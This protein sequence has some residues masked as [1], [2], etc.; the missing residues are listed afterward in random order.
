M[1]CSLLFFIL[2]AG[3]VQT[4]S[5]Q[6]ISSQRA[7]DAS[8]GRV[9]VCSCHSSKQRVVRLIL[10]LAIAL[11]SSGSSAGVS[12]A[13]FSFFGFLK[14]ALMPVNGLAWIRPQLVAKFI[15]SL[16]R[17]VKRLTVSRLPLASIGLSSSM[18]SGAVIAFTGLSEMCG[19]ICSSNE[20]QISRA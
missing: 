15:T 19:K 5:S 11:M 13:M 6:L 12:A 17:C 4:F 18:I 9:M 10:A 14:A 1:R 20:R 16:S 3:M 8:A 2:S 7:P